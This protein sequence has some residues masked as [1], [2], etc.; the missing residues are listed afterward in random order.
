MLNNLYHQND[1][2]QTT[3]KKSTVEPVEVEITEENEYVNEDAN[4]DATV[5]ASAST[6]VSS[7][8]EYLFN[9]VPI[10]SMPNDKY[11]FKP[12]NKQA[13]LSKRNVE[14]E[15][16]DKEYHARLEAL[17]V[18]ADNKHY[19]LFFGQPAAG[20]T[21]IIGSLL[22]YMKNYLKGNV[23]LDTNESTESEEELFYQL[24]DRFNKVI[25]AE[26]ITSTDT[27]QYFEL[28]IK[29]QPADSSKPQMDIIFIDASGE[30]SAQSFFSKHKV[31]SG[32]LP[33]YLTAILESNVK[34]KLAFVYDQSMKDE[35]GGI[36]QANILNSVFTQIQHIQNTHNKI[37]PK[38]LLLSKADLIVR[39]DNAA[40]ERCGKSAQMYALEKI[41]QFANGFFNEHGADNRALF[42]QMGQFSINSDLL[43]EFNEESPEKFFKWLYMQGTGG[44]SPLRERNFWEKLMH[45][46][47]TGVFE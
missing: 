40:Y 26:R 32:K 33:N 42:Y 12:K 24:Q 39:D 46:F 15:L 47:K 35:E 4:E 7:E 11:A 21:W 13:R 17:N 27:T 38:A 5:D 31:D 18:N 6:K 30:H 43:V 8:N 44:I 22:H 23:Y 37:F 1:D 29:F 45:W 14:K 20:K 2:E 16:D 3:A 28:H 19:V 9:D 36:P 25:H 10:G 41:P 34:A